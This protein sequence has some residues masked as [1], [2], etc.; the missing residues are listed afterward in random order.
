MNEA[1][2]AKG[3]RRDRKRTIIITSE[4]KKKLKEFYKKKK[5]MRL[6]KLEK[7]VRTIELASF[8]IA[9]PI[10]IAGTTMETLL[11]IRD[12]KKTD[13]QAS[14][15]LQTETLHNQGKLEL[16]ETS[17]L[18]ENNQVYDTKKQ[19]PKTIDGKEIKIPQEIE[20]TEAPNFIKTE[21]PIEKIFPDKKVE[22]KETI[23][24]K[25]SIA[26][27][28]ENKVPNQ[29]N[30]VEVKKKSQ[31]KIPLPSIDITTK[32]VGINKQLERFQEQEIIK[33]YESKLKDIR[34]D[35]KQL[36]YEYNVLNQQTNDIYESKIAENIL[37]QLSIMIK[38][39]EQLKDKLKTEIKSLENEA[40]VQYLVDSYIEE[41]KNKN[42]VEEIKDSDLY[43]LISEKLEQVETETNKLNNKVDKKKDDLEIDEE[44]FTSLKESFYDYENFNNQLIALQYEQ[45]AILKDLE[46]KI[47]NSVTE[48]ERVTYNFKMMNK[49]SK[50]LLNLLAIPMMIPGNRS[51]KAM[52]T[53]TA[54]YLLFMRNLLNP[55]LE[56]KRYR[57][58]EV[59]DYS[60]EVERG[61][62]KIE[63][64]TNLIHKTSSKLETVIKNIEKNYKDYIDNV[65][66]YKELL[67]N[68]NE[69]LADLK[70]KEEEL[71]K[72]KQQQQEL[73]ERNNNK[74]RT[75]T[76]TEEV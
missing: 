14:K 68:L 23:T 25:K 16:N 38:K 7:E 26:E 74:V 59:T 28:K 40:Y 17:V 1:I 10:A 20:I 37:Y 12:E 39:M 29:E 33:K 42:V 2:G 41:F 58:I 72:T 69:L 9:M 19:L 53:A 34:Q 46:E 60:K 71:E 21:K 63:D 36:I 35:L 70:V 52:A 45:D 5:Q 76:R 57:I 44:K 13:Y 3:G 62:S 4:N 47:S 75:L 31:T 64:A 15:E 65:P 49:Q 54:A 51:A 11:N 55:R 8:F 56:K 61:I 66:E 32:K 24:K 43:I 48:T 22:I 6:K 73:L 67:N 30:K 50:R 27:K 18:I